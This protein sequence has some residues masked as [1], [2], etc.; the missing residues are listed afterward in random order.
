MQPT[1]TMQPGLKIGWRVPS[2]FSK[3][4]I[5][6]TSIRPGC[7]FERD[8]GKVYC[9][10][11]SEATNQIE[12]AYPYIWFLKISR[13]NVLMHQSVLELGYKYIGQGSL[14]WWVKYLPKKMQP[15]FSAYGSPPFRFLPAFLRRRAK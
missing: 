9:V 11:N 5:A 3:R 8:G 2:A 15:H 14:R 4:G 10:Q 6:V 12:I 7:W 13:T 1:I